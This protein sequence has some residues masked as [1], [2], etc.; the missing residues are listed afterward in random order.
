MYSYNFMIFLWINIISYFC[1]I[2]ANIGCHFNDPILRIFLT[3]QKQLKTK[4]KVEVKFPSYLLNYVLY[5]Q[6]REG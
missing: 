2:E 4:K 6:D 3:S 5:I 1:L